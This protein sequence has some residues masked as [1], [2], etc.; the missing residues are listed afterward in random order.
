MANDIA[1][2][3][4]HTHTYLITARIN[5]FVTIQRVWDLISALQQPK[6]SALGLITIAAIDIV[7]V[8]QVWYKIGLNLQLL[9][10]YRAHDELRWN[11]MT[12]GISVPREIRTE[13]HVR[14][15]G[16]Y[17]VGIGRLH[18]CFR[19]RCT[20]SPLRLHFTTRRFN[21][22]YNFFASWEHVR[23]HMEVFAGKQRWTSGG[24][25]HGIQIELQVL[26]HRYV[27]NAVWIC[28]HKFTSFGTISNPARL[29]HIIDVAA[30]LD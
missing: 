18:V 19:H 10:E 29:Q 16:Y 4:C 6:H 9:P 14:G 21:H 8:V 28:R 15:T 24:A 1:Q 30:G 25:Q 23:R 13:M 3:Q 22:S 26:V 12:L 17:D 20:A 7:I 2:W 5:S 11:D 27:L